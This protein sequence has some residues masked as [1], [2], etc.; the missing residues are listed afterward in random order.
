MARKVYDGAKA[1]GDDSHLV[2]QM[3]A[4]LGLRSVRHES[5]PLTPRL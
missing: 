5:H 4:W 3:E 1:H 2:Q